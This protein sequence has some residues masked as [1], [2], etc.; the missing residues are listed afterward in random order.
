MNIH[1]LLNLILIILRQKYAYF[2]MMSVF[3][4]QAG[5]TLLFFDFF[6]EN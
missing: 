5:L 2:S 4:C 3:F 1:L 6:L